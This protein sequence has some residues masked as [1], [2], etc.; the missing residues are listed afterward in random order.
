MV[1]PRTI[2]ISNSLTCVPN[3]DSMIFGSYAL[4]NKLHI[5]RM[6]SVSILLDGVPMKSRKMSK[7]LISTNLIGMLVGRVRQGTVY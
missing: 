3:I 6:I 1:T 4:K 7:L 2:L 5:R